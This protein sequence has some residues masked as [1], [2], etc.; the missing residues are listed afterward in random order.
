MEK[1]LKIVFMG[2]PDFAVPSLQVL[3]E[4]GY[5]VVGVITAPDKPA[6]RG[7]K[8]Q[9]SPV[10]Q[11]AESVGLHIMQ[12]TNLK[13]EAFQQ[14]LKALEV[15]LQIVVAFRMLPEAVWDMPRIGTF[16]LHGSLLP[17]YRGAA[18]INWAIINGEKVTGVTTFFLQH[19]IDTGDVILQQEEPILEED[20]VG[21]VYGRL[22]QV[23]GELVLKTVQLVEKG[24]YETTP[25]KIVGEPKM[26]PKIFKETCKV[27]FSKDTATVYNFIRG[28][29]PYPAAWTEIL[30]KTY[31]LFKV[32]K[33]YDATLEANADGFVTDNKSY[34]YIKTADGFISVDEWQMQGKKRMELKAFLLGTKF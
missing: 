9:S 14:E 34:F 12:P 5:N 25:Q 22:M 13:N 29:S 11:Y 4:N 24:D 18:P 20:T 3:V 10:K 15:D 7:R 31:K 23:G 21:D 33:V 27:D 1:N 19:E 26:A 17:D 8:L 16:N 28:L 32:S 6:G 2:T 30:G